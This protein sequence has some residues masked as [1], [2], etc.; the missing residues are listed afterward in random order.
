MIVASLS[1]FLWSLFVIFFMVVY[2][3]ILFRVIVDIFRRRESG[4]A[5]AAWLLFI[6]FIP[7]VG[8]ITYLIV[9]STGM[10]DRDAAQI[11]ASQQSFDNYVRQVSGGTDSASQIAQAKQL[12]DSGAITQSEFEALKAKA[13]AAT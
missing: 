3:L 13:L 9:N 10:A 7:M 11:Q 4:W 8:L 12:L 5:K 2:F 1:E 6:F